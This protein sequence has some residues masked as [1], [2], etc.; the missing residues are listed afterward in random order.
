MMTGNREKA[1]NQFSS[2]AASASRYS[3]QAARLSRKLK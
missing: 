2:I 3:K 1:L